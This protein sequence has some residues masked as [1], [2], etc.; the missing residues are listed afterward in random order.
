MSYYEGFSNAVDIYNSATGAWAT[1]LL[2]V[3]R[4]VL[5]ATSVGSLAIFAGGSGA[6]V[7]GSEAKNVVD[8]YTL[9]GGWSTAR[10]SEARSWFTATT[11]G[12]LAIFAGGNIWMTPCALLLRKGSLHCMFASLALLLLVGVIRRKQLLFIIH[13]LCR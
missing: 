11:V 9:S 6:R 5:A 1:A 4:S 10:L 13:L 2:S 12:N 7:D 8:I 3:A